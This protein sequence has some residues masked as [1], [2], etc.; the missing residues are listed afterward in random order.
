MLCIVYTYIVCLYS[1]YVLLVLLCTVCIVLLIPHIHLQYTIIIP[2]YT[3]YIMYTYTTHHTL[4][5]HTHR[6]QSKT[7]L[8]RYLSQPNLPRHPPG[9]EI[10]RDENLAMF[11]LDGMVEK[12]YCQNLCY[13][14][15]VS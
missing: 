13:F 4:Y 15:K 7:D 5:T 6:I 12:I 1:I 14:A 11:E 8:T 9:N 3:P 2:A 10:Y